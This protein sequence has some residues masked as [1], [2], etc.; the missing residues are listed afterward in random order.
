MEGKSVLKSKTFWLN[1]V[2][3]LAPLVPGAGLFVQE[4]LAG[5]A[6]LWG[7]LGIVLRLLSKDRVILVE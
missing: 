2:F 4:N 7:A 1:L 3:A 5:F 6:L